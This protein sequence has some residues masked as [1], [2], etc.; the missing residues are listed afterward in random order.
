M[1]VAHNLHRRLNLN[2]FSPISELPKRL[3][4]RDVGD[5]LPPHPGRKPGAG[6]FAGL[7]IVTLLQL[8]VL[9]VVQGITEFL[10]ISSSGHLVLTSQLMG[11]PDQGLIIDIAVHAGTL[12]AVILYFWRDIWMIVAGT[13]SAL[14]GRP[15][16]GFKLLVFVVIATVPIVAAGYFGLSY[17][18]TVARS[19]ELIAWTTLGFGILLGVVDWLCMTVRRMEHLTYL[20]VIFIGCAQ[21]LALLPGTSRAGIT[22]TACRALGMERR[23]AARF[24]MLLSIPAILGATTLASLELYESGNV[25]LS[26][27]AAIAAALAFVT[28]LIA[29]AAMMQWLMRATFTPFVIYRIV[30]GGG[31]LYW[32][33][34]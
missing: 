21:A 5:R 7:H 23:E 27:D 2:L 17:I 9:A 13:A 18:K 22:M 8:L 30:L 14:T 16:P 6:G 3:H 11:W 15:A 33:Y 32:V 29:I 10:P 1:S 4:E 34:S 24:S 25:A 19:I 12:L 20:G 28:A 31:L 26:M